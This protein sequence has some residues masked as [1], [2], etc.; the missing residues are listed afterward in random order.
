MRIRIVKCRRTRIFF[1]RFCIF[2]SFILFVN[3]LLKCFRNSTLCSSAAR[4]LTGRSE[5]TEFWNFVLL[6]PELFANLNSLCCLFGHH[7]LSSASC[8]FDAL[9]CLSNSLQ[10]S[11]Y[12]GDF[13]TKGAEILFYLSARSFH[14]RQKQPW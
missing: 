13:Q 12:K 11:D 6:E 3:I 1:I 7:F 4:G 14:C 2:I 5:D 9:I 10:S 8:V